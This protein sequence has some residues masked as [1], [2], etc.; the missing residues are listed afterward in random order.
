MGR[1]LNEQYVVL[2]VHEVSEPLQVY[3]AQKPYNIRVMRF[4]QNFLHIFKFT[5]I[6]SISWRTFHIIH[7]VE[8]VP[9]MFFSAKKNGPITLLNVTHHTFTFG[10]LRMCSR[11]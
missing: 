6:Q 9:V 3:I 7:V 8:I 1:I 5:I 2:G 4:W 10:L 11:V